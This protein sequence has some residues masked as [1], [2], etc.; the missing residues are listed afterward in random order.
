MSCVLCAW[1]CSMHS[2]FLRDLCTLRVGAH[3][4]A[5]Y[6]PGALQGVQLGLRS[7]WLWSRCSEAGQLVHSWGLQ[8]NLVEG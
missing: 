6:L 7:P 3:S 5:V 8:M 4:H 1:E 2:Q